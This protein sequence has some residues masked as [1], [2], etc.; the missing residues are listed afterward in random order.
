ME[1][2]EYNNLIE[3]AIEQAAANMELENYSITEEDKNE[4]KE[5]L[6]EHSKNKVLTIK[7][8]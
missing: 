6:C 3:N 5:M 8:K 4:L 2:Q 1:N 7:K